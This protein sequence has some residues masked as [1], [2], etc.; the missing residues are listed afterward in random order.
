MSA[1]IRTRVG[2]QG[3]RRRFGLA[4]VLELGHPIEPANRD[5]KG[6][7]VCEPEQGTGVPFD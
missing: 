7:A 6:K 2:E 1:A 3:E 5:V 4:L